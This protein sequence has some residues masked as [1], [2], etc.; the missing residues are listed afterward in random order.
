[1]GNRGSRAAKGGPSD[2]SPAGK[3]N[4]LNNSLDA[5]RYFISLVML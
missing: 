3:D 2:G 1:M 4:G 5:I